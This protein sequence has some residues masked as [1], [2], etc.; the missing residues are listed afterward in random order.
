MSESLVPHCVC[1]KDCQTPFTDADNQRNKTTNLHMAP[2]VNTIVCG[3][4]MITYDNECQMR[5]DSCKLQQR[6][7]VQYL[8]KCGEYL[9]TCK[10]AIQPGLNKSTITSD[11]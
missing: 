10:S 2:F 3:S 8:G 1:P 9:V 6:I 4:N 7:N 11:H 5:L